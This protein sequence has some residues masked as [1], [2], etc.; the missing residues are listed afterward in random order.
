MEKWAL[1][2]IGQDIKNINLCLLNVFNK[3]LA[4]L[5]LLALLPL[6]AIIALLIY[7]DSGGPIF[8]RQVRVG[9]NYQQFYLIKFRTM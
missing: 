6:F 4:S 8:F 3:A 2:I 1:K 7:L 5:A 9:K